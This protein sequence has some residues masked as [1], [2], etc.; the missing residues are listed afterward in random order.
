MRKSSRYKHRRRKFAEEA[1]T[2]ARGSLSLANYPVIFAGFLQKGIPEE[3]ILPR[4]NVLTFHAW[5][6]LGRTVLGDVLWDDPH[7][8]PEKCQEIVA[9][10]A[11]PVGARL[12][13]LLRECDEAVSGAGGDAVE[14][15]AAV[16]KLQQTEEEAKKLSVSGNGRAAKALKYIAMERV[17]LQAQALGMDVDTATQILKA[18]G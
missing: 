4:E 8:Q 11:N 1:L 17:K 3:E 16:K 14:Q 15:L 10:I 9:K 12:N 7:E 13:E 5:R 6:A 18:R 2:R